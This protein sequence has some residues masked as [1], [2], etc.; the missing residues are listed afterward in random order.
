MII[1]PSAAM[2]PIC[3][4]TEACTCLRSSSEGIAEEGWS[5]VERVA[6]AKGRWPFRASGMPT[7][8]HSAMSGFEDMACSM[9]PGVT[10]ALMNFE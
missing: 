10:L 5:A 4:L 9:D 3:S 8:Q 7:T 6:K 1:P 2:A